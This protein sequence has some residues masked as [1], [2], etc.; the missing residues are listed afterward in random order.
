MWIK[1]SL[2]KKEEIIEEEEED[3]YY[4]V[5]VWA[6]HK[7]ND[8]QHQSS[9]YSLWIRR[10]VDLI[11]TEVEVKSLLSN[12]GVNI[13]SFKIISISKWTES[14]YYSYS[15][16]EITIPNMENP[17]SPVKEEEI[18][19][20]SLIDKAVENEDYEEAARLKKEFENKKNDR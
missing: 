1:Q 20:Q 14:D 9:F 3:T 16:G 5:G 19:Y 11:P 7:I 18:D 15:Q 2:T 13:I 10:G 17:I 8:D 12:L 4:F 6:Y